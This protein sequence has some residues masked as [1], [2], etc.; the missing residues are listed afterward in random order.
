MNTRQVDD[1]SQSLELFKKKCA[2]THHP[3]LFD[4]EKWF[5]MRTYEYNPSHSRMT[6]V[7]SK[8]VKNFFTL[9]YHEDSHSKMKFKTLSQAK[10]KAAILG[11]DLYVPNYGCHSSVL[12]WPQVCNARKI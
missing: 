11:I 2:V 3:V 1:H 7:L 8:F 12:F 6:Y 4:D 5:V 10:L 9:D